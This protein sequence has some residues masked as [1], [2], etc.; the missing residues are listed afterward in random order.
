VDV[1]EYDGDRAEA[2][3]REALGPGVGDAPIE[4]LGVMPWTMRAQVADSYRAANVLLAGDA[5]H[6]FPPTGGLGLNTGV[7]DAHNL[8]W[9][10]GAVLDGWATDALLDTYGTERSAIALRNAQQSLAN[11]AEMSALSVLADAPPESDPDRLATW[12]DEPGR[13][14][15]IADAIERQRPHFD[16]LALQLGF[17]YDPDDEPIVDVSRFVPRAAP[18]RRLPHGWLTIDG[19]RHSVLELLDPDA[20]TVLLL[21]EHADEPEAPLDAPVTVARLHG[22]DPDVRAWSETVGLDGAAAVLTR[23][24]GHVLSIATD[25]D[26]LGSFAQAIARLVGSAQ[27]TGTTWT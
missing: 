19:E 18:G 16:S 8:A 12:L 1:T 17:S 20:F 24:D 23:P 25:P 10:L 22:D 11:F 5:A 9:K 14:E 26:E 3:I 13:R 4:V 27:A 6:R 2:L 21:D 7:Q 15:Q